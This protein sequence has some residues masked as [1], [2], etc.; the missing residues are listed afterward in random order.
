MLRKNECDRDQLRLSS[1]LTRSLL[2]DHPQAFSFVLPFE[3][4]QVQD[5]VRKESFISGGCTFKEVLQ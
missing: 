4:I 3:G 2:S 5:A 1:S